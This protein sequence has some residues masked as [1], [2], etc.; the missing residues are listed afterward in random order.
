VSAFYLHAVQRDGWQTVTSSVGRYATSL[1][2][3]KPRTGAS[4]SI[5]AVGLGTEVYIYT[6]P[7]L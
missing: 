3:K 6:Y 5:A 1:A 4:I 7:T 2:V